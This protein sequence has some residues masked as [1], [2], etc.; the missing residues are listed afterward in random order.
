MKRHS[1]LV[2]AAL[3]AMSAA[4]LA[5]SLDQLPFAKKLKLAKVGD[6]EAQIAVAM[7]Y[8]TGSDTKLDAAEAAKWYREAA[9]Q[10]NVEAQ[11]R[12]ARIVGKGA[13]GLKQDYPT[14]IK[15][16][17]AAA[18]KGHA[19]AMNALGLMHQNGE[20]VAA[21]PAK[22]AEW[23]GKA[24]DAKL[25]DAENNLGMLY[26]N[27]KGVPRDLDEAFKL[28]ARAADQGDG[29]G[30]NNLGGMHEMGWGTPKDRGKAIE[31]YKQ[32]AAKGIAAGQENLQRLAAT[33]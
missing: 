5:Q 15:L 19:P 33:P 30:L 13:K 32:A 8:E 29:W 4:G 9:L 31:L 20:G 6:E 18:A 21:D 1:I 7:A 26:L 22:A 16:Y 11:F 17:E 12:L 25:A 2:A 27:G 14:A 10:G 23:F 3:I 24:A 28:F